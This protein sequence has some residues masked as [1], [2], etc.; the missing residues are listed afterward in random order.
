MLREKDKN[1]LAPLAVQIFIKGRQEMPRT[2]PGKYDRVMLSLPP[3][4]QQY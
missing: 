3:D 4:S 2:C 1:R